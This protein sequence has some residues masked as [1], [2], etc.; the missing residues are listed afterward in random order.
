M[1]IGKIKTDRFNYIVN[2]SDKL[3]V[4][5]Y[6]SFDS[7]KLNDM[8]ILSLFK[9]IYDGFKGEENFFS[10]NGC[11]AILYDVDDESNL[12]KFDDKDDEFKVF[13][14]GK[15]KVIGSKILF[16]V[17]SLLVL[18][19]VFLLAGNVFKDVIAS[20]K[21]ELIDTL[22]EL[23]ELTNENYGLLEDISDAQEEKIVKLEDFIVSSYDM[24]GSGLYDL[25]MNNSNLTSE[26]KSLIANNDYL[27]DI[28]GYMNDSNKAELIYNLVNL[29]IENFTLT[30]LNESRLLGYVNLL[31]KSVIHIRD[32]NETTLKEALPH[33]FVHVTQDAN[34]YL[35]VSESMA[36]IMAFEYYDKG[37]SSYDFCIKYLRALMEIIG[38]QP[39]MELTYGG[40][41]TQFENI[42]KS[43][44]DEDDAN[45][46][47]AVLKFSPVSEINKITRCED[48]L[49]EI[50]ATLY[51][52][53]Y[54]SEM[55]DDQAINY[56]LDSYMVDR[57]YF[58][59]RKMSLNEEGFNAYY[60]QCL[61]SEDG[62]KICLDN[63]GILEEVSFDDAIKLKN[64]EDFDG[65]F[66]FDVSSIS[67]DGNVRVIWVYEDGEYHIYALR[68]E[69]V[70][71]QSIQTKFSGDSKVLKK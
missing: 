13:E 60:L 23:N 11:K 31:D 42:I 57:Y 32:E 8:Q 9:E 39:I 44:L 2:L 1:I 59:S 53:V 43:Y 12:E 71:S 25:I 28:I 70:T 6:S 26:Q 69:F 49:N 58:N 48:R 15:F 4:Y 18:I 56:I 22:E 62:I 3:S 61:T 50:L 68:T 30:E 55:K 21:N 41:V 63:D 40:D 46:L 5:G 19:N 7:F 45:D 14:I 65:K 33:E 16:T 36:E 67:N 54:D 64:S 34:S 52:K 27:E 38:P 66:I 29:N 51:N 17:I 24:S 10:N 35:F 37:I 20:K 47:L